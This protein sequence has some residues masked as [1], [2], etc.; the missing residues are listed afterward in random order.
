MISEDLEIDTYKTR[1]RITSSDSNVTVLNHDFTEKVFRNDI[2][3]YN[4]D[5]KPGGSCEDELDNVR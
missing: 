1:T 2:K 5:P 3:R 4:A